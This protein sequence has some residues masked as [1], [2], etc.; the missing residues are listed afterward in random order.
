MTQAT[1]FDVE[2]KKTYTLISTVKTFHDAL[3]VVAMQ[4]EKNGYANPVIIQPADAEGNI[5]ILEEN[6]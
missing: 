1:L 3:D 6:P 4:R 5:A 2:S